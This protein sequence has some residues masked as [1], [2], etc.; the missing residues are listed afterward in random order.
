MPWLRMTN[1]PASPVL[2]QALHDAYE[3]LRRYYVALD[4]E[5]ELEDLQRELATLRNLMDTSQGSNS[6]L[7][8]FLGAHLL[9]R[10]EES[11]RV[12]SRFGG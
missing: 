11:V 1:P 6:E 2:A 4:T 10:V 9:G 7:L 8:N 5:M 12:R 3:A